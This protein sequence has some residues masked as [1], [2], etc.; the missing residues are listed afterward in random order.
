VHATAARGDGAY[1]QMLE[2]GRDKDLESAL[3]ELADL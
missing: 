3:A 1:Q 2:L